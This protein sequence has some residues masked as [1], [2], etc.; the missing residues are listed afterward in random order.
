MRTDSAKISALTAAPSKLEN[1][2]L[3]STTQVFA[4][5]PVLVHTKGVE[6]VNT[7][8]VTVF[9]GAEGFVNSSLYWAA[10]QTTTIGSSPTA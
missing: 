8:F 6:G 1:I 2:S 4:D 7:C 5:Q 3:S 9:L 10:Q